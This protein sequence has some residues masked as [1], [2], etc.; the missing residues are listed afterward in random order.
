M[1]KTVID[2]CVILDMFLIHRPEHA[3]AARL[4]EELNERNIEVLL[5]MHAFFE[6]T[7]AIMCEKRLAQGRGLVG[8]AAISKEQP[9]KLTQV[10]IDLKFVD[11]YAT[12]Q[13]PDLASGDMIFV[14]LAYH[15][16]LDL[17]TEDAKM[18]RE[19]QRFGVAAFNV[20][21]Y[22]SRLDSVR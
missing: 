17:V 14:L 7:S 16:G 9:L 11:R 1:S 10:P 15:D 22:L 13:M 20:S 21:D 19:A 6:L 18:L 2:T 5:P 3:R 8:N 12:G 4:V